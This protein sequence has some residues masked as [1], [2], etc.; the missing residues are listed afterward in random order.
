MQEKKV[1]IALLMLVLVAGMGVT[2]T[3]SENQAC[4]SGDAQ[5]LLERCF[6]YLLGEVP[7][8]PLPWCCEGVSAVFQLSKTPQR[9]RDV[10]HCLKRD[11]A[12]FHF[13]PEKLK[14]LPQDCKITSRFS[15][16]PRQNCNS[17]P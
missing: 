5:V 14:M 1:T 17:I 16:D 10:C 3:L 13:D 15:L 8:G 6:A 7:D 4:A 9:R 11:T 12:V 2:T